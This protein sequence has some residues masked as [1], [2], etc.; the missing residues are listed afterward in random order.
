MPPPFL[1][2][3]TVF[4]CFFKCTKKVAENGYETDDALMA[5]PGQV[6]VS[7]DDET[8]YALAGSEHYEEK[9]LWDYEITYEKGENGKAYWSDSF[10]NVMFDA[11]SKPWPDK[12]NL[13]A[14]GKNPGNVS[15]YNLFMPLSDYEKTLKQEI[16]GPVWA[17]IALDSGNYT[18]PENS[19]VKVKATRDAY[20]NYILSKQLKDGGWAL[21]GDVAEADITGMVLLSGKKITLLY[22]R[23]CKKFQNEL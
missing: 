3:I 9:T 23:C 17:L 4:L 21:S 5:E 12:E 11:A 7:E 14:I 2:I 20:I 18:I 6:Y 22:V 1:N 16:N 13:T 8:W 10:G 19:A 15:G